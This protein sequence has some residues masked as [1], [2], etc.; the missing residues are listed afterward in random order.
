MRSWVE[1]A[2]ATAFA[3]SVRPFGARHVVVLALIFGTLAAFLVL[4]FRSLR[5][6]MSLAREG[7]SAPS[8]QIAPPDD[9]G[10]RG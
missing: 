5:H 10:G 9:G 7:T 4:Q 2:V 6:A 8:V 1:V 3:F